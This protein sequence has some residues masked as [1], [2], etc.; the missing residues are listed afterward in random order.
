MTTKG[1]TASFRDPDG[2]VFYNQ[3]KLQRYLSPELASEY[4]SLKPLYEALLAEGWL[5]P[6]SAPEKREDGSLILTP[7]PLDF[8]SYPYE[9]C[10]SQLKA[11]ARQTLAIQR[12]ALDFGATLIDA[13]AFNVPMHKGKPVLID[14]PSL[15]KRNEGEPWA[16]YR[17]FCEHFLAPLALMAAHGHGAQRLTSLHIDGIPLHFASSM[18]SWQTRLKPGLAAH[19]HLHAKQQGRSGSGYTNTNKATPQVSENGMRGLIDNLDAT[20]AGLTLP[21]E[22]TVWGDYYDATNYSSGA[23]AA[24]ERVVAELIDRVGSKPKTCWDFG[25]ND[26]RFSRLAAQRGLFTLALDLDPA[27]I[28][29]AWS[30]VQQRKETNLLPLVMDLTDPSPA[31]GFA[32]TER[33][34][35]LKRGPADLGLALAL[36]HHLAIGHNIPMDRLAAFFADSCRWLILEFVPKPDS[37]VQ[38]LLASRRD[39]F[40]AYHEEGFQAAFEPYFT[41]LA[42]A[43][44]EGSQRT[45][46]LLERRS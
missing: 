20:V 13:S 35:L 29:H 30:E 37:Q 40:P 31:R 39:I 15:R 36:I 16:G 18:L 8:M 12:K 27:A 7:E 22:K 44:I 14:L 9:W 6:H 11:A 2:F 21:V 33:D 3:G 1:H 45:L 41:F 32:H 25:A 26:A 46:Y 28:E 23:M 38:R 19:I 42:N 43:R 24:K 17:Q 34:S 5:L 4:D 10:F